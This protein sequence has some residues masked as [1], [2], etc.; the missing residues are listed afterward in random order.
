MLLVA[1]LTAEI[2]PTRRDALV[3]YLVRDHD[4]VQ[5][6]NSAPAYA[7]AVR[8][9]TELRDEAD[10]CWEIDHDEWTAAA[11]HMGSSP[12]ATTAAQ[13]LSQADIPPPLKARLVLSIFRV[14]D[15]LPTT[16]E[17]KNAHKFELLIG[18]VAQTDGL[19]AA[20]DLVRTVIDAT[21]DTEKAADVLYG[22]L[23]KHCFS[24]PN[25]AALRELLVLPL[26]GSE[27]ERL[28]RLALVPG[29]LERPAAAIA[30]DILLAKLI[31]QGKY[32][33]AIQ[34]DRRAVQHEASHAFD[35]SP[36]LRQQ[37]KALLDGAWSILPAVQ[38][39][40]LLAEDT[41]TAD[42][43]TPMEADTSPKVMST[44]IASNPAMDTSV[45]LTNVPAKSLPMSAS[46][47][48]SVPSSPDSRLLRTTLHTTNDARPKAT[49]A[50]KL[51]SAPAESPTLRSSSPFAGLKR[52]GPQ[53]LA[54]SQRVTPS[55]GSPVPK[56]STPDISAMDEVLADVAAM[57]H[58][59]EYEI[60]EQAEGPVVAPM[61]DESSERQERPRRA[62]RS[63]ARRA[64]DAIRRGSTGGDT[65]LAAGSYEERAEDDTE[66]A[67]T[68]AAEEPKSM[69]EEASGA[70]EELQSVPEDENEDAGDISIPGG[71]PEPTRRHT[72]HSAL[73]ASSSMHDMKEKSTPAFSRS[74]TQSSVAYPVGSL[75][76]LQALQD[77]EPIARRTRAARAEIESRGSQTSG[78]DV[79][80]SDGIEAVQTPVRRSR[81][82]RTKT[83]STRSR[84]QR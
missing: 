76:R 57:E 61:D 32:V 1:I 5:Q 77:S 24:P 7:E 69:E 37:R 38:R 43:N 74:A 52:P 54:S 78:G 21:S 46:L 25:Q 22:I 62:R 27:A 19:G 71:F 39:N 59:N 83:P 20:W 53:A 60:A 41:G 33:D 18:A 16:F 2:E 80:D 34:L 51:K 11:A 82:T 44:D 70:H 45:H 17:D 6:S 79:G 26:T 8:L 56:M 50:D 47:R 31:G 81:R 12:L 84:R 23:F 67:P 55:W 3:Y 68:E 14:H 28:E 64:S 15:K 49:A 36:L 29:S 73:P 75:A 58:E 72:R 35:T 10:G 9:S 63:A 42:E 48:S 13:V 66:M 40:A 4:A 30:V 65:G